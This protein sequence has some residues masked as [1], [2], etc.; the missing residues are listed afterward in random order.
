LYRTNA[1]RRHQDGYAVPFA[2]FLLTLLAAIA[3]VLDIGR[4]YLAQRTLQ[5][6]AD[7]A[8]LDSAR[9][10]SRC[11]SSTVPQYNDIVASV[12]ASLLRN[13]IDDPDVD[14]ATWTVEHG[15]VET[16]EGT[17]FRQLLPGSLSE[18]D[19]VRVTLQRAVPTPVMPFLRAG[20]GRL[21]TASATASQSALGNLRVGSSLASLEDGAVNALL[22]ALLEGSVSIGAVGYQG[23]LGANLTLEQLALALDLS[24]QD[25]SD[26]LALGTETPIL[27]DV[28][29]NLATQLSGAVSMQV[30]NSLQDLAG[31]TNNNT[32]IPLDAVLQ[33]VGEIAS[34]VPFVNLGEL[35]MALA[36]ATHADS[37]GGVA[38]IELPISLGLL[39]INVNSFL[40]VLEPP[41]ISPMGRPGETSASTA[42]VRLMVRLQVNTISSITNALNV[43]LLGLV[44]FTLD[45]LKVG[46]DVEVSPA[47]GYLDRI[48]CPRAGINDGYPQADL[49]ARATVATV[50]LGTFSGNA[51]DASDLESAPAPITTVRLSVLLLGTAQL[52]VNVTE[53]VDVSV[54]DDS[55]QPLPL[56]VTEFTQVDI[57]S[58]SPWVFQ[59]DGIPPEAPVAANPQT[60]SS[61]ELL[62]STLGTLLGDLNLELSPSG[63]SGVL[64]LVSGL[65]SGILNT[66]ITAISDLL[67]PILTGVGGIV[68]AILDPLLHLLGVE[69]GQA[70][71][72]MDTVMVDEPH[73]VSIEVPV[74]E[75]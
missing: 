48:D 14:L 68:D 54:G 61:G 74:A 5:Q 16:D 37:E 43:L 30:I 4:L 72:I 39:G 24:V 8:A 47:T 32:P 53:P 27:S 44:N 26:P 59:A 23:L 34:N 49:S 1:F 60:L 56:T 64:A 21:L 29:S 22:S 6:Q 3:I 62:S 36:M 17:Q 33:P 52:A 58:D 55:I 15:T 2:A 10:V 35:I 50:A 28:I 9:I 63:S 46:I 7:L 18:A 13:G 20:D 11:N 40:Q 57:G 51:S 71:V 25:L 75:E 38:P 41:Q 12:Q 66:L 42:Q 31:Q 19:A 69:S 65:L 70:T 45:P 67:G 73:L